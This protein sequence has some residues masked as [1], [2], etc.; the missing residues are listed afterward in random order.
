MNRHKYRDFIN[1][2]DFTLTGIYAIWDNDE[3]IYVGQSNNIVK[4]IKSH[5]S[6]NKLFYEMKDFI[7]EKDYITAN[8]K[9]DGMCNTLKFYCHIHERRD[10]LDIEVLEL[11]NISELNEKEEY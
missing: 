7:K 4:R 3:V 8:D 6:K 11:C 1:Y 9:Y 10:V 5:F 2:N